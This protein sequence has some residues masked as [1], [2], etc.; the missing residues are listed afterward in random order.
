[1]PAASP[2]TLVPYKG[3]SRRVSLCILG[4]GDVQLRAPIG[5]AGEARTPAGGSSSQ[6]KTAAATVAQHSGCSLQ[7]RSHQGKEWRS[8][9]AGL[10]ILANQGQVRRQRQSTD[11]GSHI[12]S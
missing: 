11:S 9:H 6:A 12:G 1:M 5:Q 10:L 2:G 4:T 3:D 7:D 8:N